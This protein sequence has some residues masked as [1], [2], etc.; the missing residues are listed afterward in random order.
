MVHRPSFAKNAH[1]GYTV[2]GYKV[3]NDPWILVGAPLTYRERKT[4][5]KQLTVKNKE[6]A[7]YRCSIT[8]PNN[9]YMLPFD[10]KDYHEIRDQYGVYQSENKTDQLLGATLTVS[11]DVI[12][13]CAPNYR[14]VSRIMRQDEFRYE[15]TGICFTLKDRMRKF[16]EHS[17]CRNSMWGHHRQGYCQA[18]F[19]AV[20]SKND[21]SLVVAAPGAWYWQG[22][23]F[24]ISQLNKQIKHK[25][26]EKSA[27]GNFDDSYRGYSIDLANFDNDVYEDLIVSSPRANNCK[28]YIE[29]FDASFELL[30]VLHGDQIGAYF[31][32]AVIAL[33]VNN[34]GFNDII[35]GSPM[36]KKDTDNYDVGQITVFMRDAKYAGFVFKRTV[37]NGFRAKSR[38][39]STLAKLGDVND[40]G[41]A[42]IAVKS[43]NLY[44]I[45]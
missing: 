10:K 11:D 28:G 33:D 8:N 24:S 17:P 35:V 45:A 34:D 26:P 22:M 18:G 12:L 39:G 29:I 40:D 32:S 2:A 27:E 31:G 37:L 16:E 43:L 25:Y 36:F 14:Y 23:I 21:S 9:C 44:F 7:V 20:I 3:A 19:S 6:G 13:A 42:D 1:F 38:F 30:H 4:G 41:Y 15:P 5:N